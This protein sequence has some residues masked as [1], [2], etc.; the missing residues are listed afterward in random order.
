MLAELTHLAGNVTE[1]A[2]IQHIIRLLQSVIAHDLLPPATVQHWLAELRKTATA[3]ETPEVVA[4]LTELLHTIEP[5]D[6]NPHPQADA[7]PID[8]SFSDADELY[9][10]NAGLVLLGPLLSHFFKHLALL[11][12]EQFKDAAAMQRAVGLLQYL[13]TEEPFP[14]EYLLP[15]NKVLCGMELT[16]V[17]DFG[18][19]VSEAE[20]EECAALLTAVIAQAPILN[21]MSISS[22]RGTFLLRQGVL[23]A[24]DGAWLLQ[25]EREAYDVVL[26]RFPWSAQWVKWPWME[27]P[28]RVEW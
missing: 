10:A 17:F 18:P 19:P 14:P 6:A 16:D 3:G 20:A 1:S 23:S 22:F 26:D 21:D 4:A 15:L 8:L 7:A 24:R 5:E 28:L 11:D 25:V 9:I 27:A 12:D 13:A 2:A